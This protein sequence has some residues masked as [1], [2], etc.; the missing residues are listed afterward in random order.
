MF[1]FLVRAEI[2]RYPF[3][4]ETLKPSLLDSN[5]WSVLRKLVKMVWIY[6][7]NQRSPFF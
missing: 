5:N 3:Y 2:E 4:I 1:P 6:F 7:S